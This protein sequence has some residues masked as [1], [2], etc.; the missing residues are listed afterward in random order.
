M[1]N[2]FNCFSC[3]FLGRRTVCSCTF[4]SV[5]FICSI[6]F[7]CPRA[8]TWSLLDVSVLNIYVRPS[9]A[10]VSMCMY[11]CNV[12]AYLP[13]ENRRLCDSHRSEMS[14]RNYWNCSHR[15]Q[16]ILWQMHDRITSVNYYSKF[17]WLQFW[18]LLWLFQFA[19]TRIL[20]FSIL[21]SLST[22]STH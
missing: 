11:V 3:L 2:N 13:I 6:L 1:Q 12:T 18:S 7:S 15:K 17:L 21:L 14:V 5:F 19:W 16:A 9:S 10:V 22:H 8:L 20:S 4:R